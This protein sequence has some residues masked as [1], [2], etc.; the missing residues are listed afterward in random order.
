MNFKLTIYNNK[1]YKEVVLNPESDRITIGTGKENRVCFLKENF[2]RE[3]HVEIMKQND[4]FIASTE[5]DVF[6]RSEGSV[7]EKIHVFASGDCVEVC[8]ASTERGIVFLDFGED[9]GDKQ[10]NYNLQITLGGVQ[11]FTLGGSSDCDIVINNDA[12][13]GEKVLFRRTP[14]GFEV[15]QSGSHYGVMVNGFTPKNQKRIVVANEHFFEYCGNFFYLESDCIYTS[16]KGQVTTRL[17][18]FDI[19]PQTNHYKYPQFLRS[20][21]QQYLDPSEKPEVLPPKNAPQEPKKNLFMILLPTVLTLFLMVFIRGRMMGGNKMFVIYFAATMCISGMMSVW[22]YINSNKDFKKKMIK[23]TE[24]YNEYMDKKEEELTKMRQEERTLESEK[25]RSLEET[26]R[27][28]NDFSSRLFE[29]EKDHDD[30]LTVRIG[31]GRVK[32]LC[33]IDFKKQEYVETEDMLMYYPERCMTST[34]TSTTCRWF[35][36]WQ[37]AM[38]SVLWA[39]GTSCTR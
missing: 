25:N 24:I 12:L 37:N 9:F 16:D 4:S 27:N 38:P 35:W 33:Q 3:F 29:K 7:K 22:N 36:S 18:T 28:I 23:R 13:R 1:L 32:S 26:V 21:R 10:D 2:W 17:K 15:D 34:S 14:Q 20:A 31:N 5:D 30:F 19:L 8:D 6:F 39:S 11:Q